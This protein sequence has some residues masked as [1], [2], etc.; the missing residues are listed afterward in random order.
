MVRSNDDRSLRILISVVVFLVL[1]VAGLTLFNFVYIPRVK[2]C[3]FVNK[4]VCFTGSKFEKYNWQDD[5]AGV[6]YK[7][8]QPQKIQ[9]PFDGWMVLS[10][11]VN[12][13]YQGETVGVAEAMEFHSDSL[14]TMMVVVEKANLLKGRLA[15]RQP[16][17]KGEIVA[18]ILP[19][20]ISFMDNFS[21]IQSSL[22]KK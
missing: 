17:V 4:I 19:E 13:N 22:L 5:L 20:K 14:G 10:P 7:L 18:E 12:I 1:A 3:L 2:N 8:T 21:F 9:A 16:V 15:E 11:F 6:G